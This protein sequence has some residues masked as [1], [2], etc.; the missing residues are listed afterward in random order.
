MSALDSQ[1]PTV[2]YA[3]LP[4]VRLAYYE[5]GP[6]RGVPVIFC[7]GFPE[8][9]FSWRHQLRAFEAAGRWAIA[10]DQR[11]YGLTSRPQ[12]VEA[13]DIETLT[14]DIVGLLDRL[15]VEKAVLCGHDWGG[16]VVWQ[17][18]LRHADRVAGVIGVNTPFMARAPADPI[19]IMRTRFGD[20]MYIVNFQKPGEAD[21]VLAA[22]VERTMS[23]FMRRPLPG[24]PPAS[25]GLSG[26]AG[27][28]GAPVQTFSFL[29]ALQ[30]WD[31]RFDPRESLLKPEEMAFF[32]ESFQRTGFTG[33][34]NWYRNFTRNWERSA[35]I[36]ERVDVPS[37]M[38][39]A[40]LDAVLPPSA[41]DGMETY[42]P[43][44]EK[45]LIK[46]SGHW[47]QQE[48]PD[49]VNRA[50]LDWMDRRFPA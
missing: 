34:I 18:P 5:V 45:H 3:D 22:D 23:F 47:T 35:G 17:A 19:A 43:N 10:P 14:G 21:A 44:L 25:G 49:E 48:K 50:I 29:K 30:A 39:M 32:I 27:Q 37:L 9:A 1:M 46:G 11:G 8:L 41:A 38:I 28:D 15:G 13:Y 20:D 40:E 2:A 24:A 36:V 33:G 42:V 16:I 4:D 26:D 6:R 31:P 7:H 12:A